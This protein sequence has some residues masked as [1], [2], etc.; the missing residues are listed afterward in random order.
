V[1]TAAS[2]G[3]LVVGPVDD[4]TG[5]RDPSQACVPS[6]ETAAVEGFDAVIADWR[7]LTLALNALNRSLGKDDLYPFDLPPA[8]TEKLA[9]VHRVIT[10]TAT[11]GAA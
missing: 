1:Q 6:E 7:P 9:F 8:V 4:R 10:E 11:A 3:V 5:R 2:F